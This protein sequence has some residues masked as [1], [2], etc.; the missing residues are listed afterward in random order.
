MFFTIVCSFVM[1]IIFLFSFVLKKIKYNKNK[2]IEQKIKE[3]VRVENA[4]RKKV[5]KS[6]STELVLALEESLEERLA[7]HRRSFD[8]F[9]RKNALQKNEFFLECQRQ[10]R[11]CSD[12][13]EI[14]RR[15]LLK[16]GLI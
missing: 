4:L 5:K 11:Y 13:R 10:A 8:N 16:T 1:T 7:G 6:K 9:C 14:S 15:A 3:R 12:L 2:Q